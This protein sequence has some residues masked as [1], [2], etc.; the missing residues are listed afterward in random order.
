MS[1]SDATPEPPD[2]LLAEIERLLARLEAHPDAATR[3]DVTALLQHIDTIH[4]VG[5]TRLVGMIESLAGEP[6]INRLSRDPGIRLLLQS[7]DLLE[8]DRRLLADEALDPVRGSLH[9]AGVDLELREVVGSVV[10]VRVLRRSEGAPRPDDI[11]PTI[12]GAL[13]ED[14]LGFQEL[15][16]EEPGSEAVVPLSSIAVARKPEFQE[17]LK[18]D[19]LPPGQLAARDVAA[20]P[21]LV[22]RVD[23]GVLAV[24]NRCGASPLPLQFGR[25]EGTRLQCS[26]HGCVYDLQSGLRVDREGTALE[27][28]RARERDGR[29]EVELAL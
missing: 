12:E 6:F 29:I 9:D 3:A 8:V 24:R 20:H 2:D 25:L 15:V 1:E 18:S 13:R 26:W 5:L 21:V 17:V 14:F 16:L 22:A 7:Y 10:Y 23:D 19:E 27:T 11:R 4:R 28:Y